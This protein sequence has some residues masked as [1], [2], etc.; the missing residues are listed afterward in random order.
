MNTCKPQPVAPAPFPPSFFHHLRRHMNL[1]TV[2]F[3]SQTCFDWLH[4]LRYFSRCLYQNKSQPLTLQLPQR[5]REVLSPVESS[6][7]GRSLA[8]ELLAG[9]VHPRNKTMGRIHPRVKTMGRIHR[10]VKTFKTSQKA[11]QS[12]FSRPLSPSSAAARG[13]GAILRGLSL[14]HTA[15][16][17]SIPGRACRSRGEKP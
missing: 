11:P 5:K 4:F 16:C 6:L 13:R 1:Q 7:K 9:T 8:E 14:S 2:W 3:F 10:R 17:S 15:L 12:G